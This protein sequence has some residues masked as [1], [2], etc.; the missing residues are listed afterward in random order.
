[1]GRKIFNL[2]CFTSFLDVN[3]IPSRIGPKFTYILEKRR[4]CPS[5]VRSDL[6]SYLGTYMR[7]LHWIQVDLF[8]QSL[9]PFLNRFFEGKIF[10]QL[11]FDNCQCPNR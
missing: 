7:T 9:N 5:K 1:M 8:E 3:I 4:W 10:L 6:S 2:S 11:L